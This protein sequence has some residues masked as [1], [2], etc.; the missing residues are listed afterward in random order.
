MLKIIGCVSRVAGP[1]VEAEGGQD[2][3]MREMAEVGDEHLVGEVVRLQAGKIS[4]QVYEDTTSLKPGAPVYGSGLPLAV[5]LGPGLIGTIF[6]GIQRPLDVLRSVSGDFVGRGLSVPALDRKKKWHFK[7]LVKVGD[8]LQAGAVIGTVQETSLVEHRVMLPP[9]M[10]GKVIAVV[11]ENDWTIEEDVVVIADGDKEHRVAM[12]Q[13]W[14][15]RQPRPYLSRESLDEPLI[16]G[17]RVIDALFPVAKGG[18]VAVPG[19]FGTGKTVVQHQIAKWCDADIILFIGCGERGNEMTDVLLNFSRLIDARSGKPLLERTVFV[20]NTSN[21][22]VAAREASIYTGITMA[23]YYRDMGYNVAVMADSTSRWA[24]ALR[25]LSGRM[26][27]LP[28]DEGFPAY[29]PIRLAE[30]YERAGVVTTLSGG[31][32][33]VTIIGSVSPP[34]GDFS[35]PVTQHSQRYVR[36]FWSLDRDLA[37]ARHYPSISW[38]DSY[39]EYLHDVEPWWAKNFDPAW[40]AMRN[41]IIELLQKETRLLQVVKLVG[42]D[43]LP[44]S[45]KMILETCGIFK[46]GF[47]QQSAF[48]AVDMYTLPAKQVRMLKVILAFHDKG[49]EAIRSGVTLEEVRTSALRTAILKMRFVYRNEDIEQLDTLLKVTEGFSLKAEAV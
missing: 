41:R 14:P 42:P 49:L 25:E 48:D 11:A 33:S 2:A 10:Q 37:N 32:G 4:I 5:D 24:E 21:M 43:V 36:C 40:L 18:S 30:F 45:Q 17:Q 3:H 27:E 12:L 20:A 15:V 29:L 16:T 46:N 34:G 38:T 31:R 13:R 1:L 28:A 35:E 39:S 47:L 44:D 22:P 7:P 6:D 23:E 26:E 9:Q 19:G 8:H